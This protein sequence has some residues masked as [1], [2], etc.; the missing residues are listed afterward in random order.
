M[1]LT[2]E[3][4]LKIKLPLSDETYKKLA[5]ARENNSIT[6]PSLVSR[7]LSQAFNKKKA[8]IYDQVY[9]GNKLWYDEMEYISPEKRDRILN[10]RR[11]KEAQRLMQQK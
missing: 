2:K 8:E 6:P 3:D 11:Q 10:Q 5:I 1:V 9:P 4:L 7:E